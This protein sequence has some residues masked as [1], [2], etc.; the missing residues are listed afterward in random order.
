M[1]KNSPCWSESDEPASP[2]GLSSPGP[3]PSGAALRSFLEGRSSGPQEREISA[4]VEQ[5][6]RCRIALGDLAT[7][8]G[9][10]EW[11][12]QCGPL[13]C[14]PAAGPGL[15]RLID[16]LAAMPGRGPGPR[17]SPPTPLEPPTHTGDPGTVVPY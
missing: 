11:L 4:H 6:E 9:L 10:R 3:C 12:R 13:R 16:R 7:D 1:P 14:G 2:P 8:P 15:A 5:C 17:R